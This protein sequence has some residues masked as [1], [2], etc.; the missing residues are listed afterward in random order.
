MQMLHDPAR[1][2]S[3]RSLLLA[4][5]V[6]AVAAL[7]GCNGEE[8]VYD[9]LYLQIASETPIEQLRIRFR[10]GAGGER[11]VIGADGEGGTLVDL[12]PG[13]NL[14]GLPYIVRIE[15]GEAR[16]TRPTRWRRPGPARSIS[17]SGGP[18]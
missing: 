10:A 16:A 7:S 5:A 13:V 1:R 6:T 12:P 14:L 18:W 8:Q 15:P 2:S 4:A 3:R 9:T 11:R 17:A